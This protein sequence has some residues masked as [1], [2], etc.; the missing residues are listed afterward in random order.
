MGRAMAVANV[1]GKLR[2]EEKLTLGGA[3]ARQIIIDAPN[4][5]VLVSR[6]LMLDKTLVQAL[7]AGSSNVENEP[8]TKRFLDR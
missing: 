3:P 6:F 2:K 8:D 4:N 1:K 5:I 7:V